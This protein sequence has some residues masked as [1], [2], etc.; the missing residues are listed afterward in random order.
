MR[1]GY[2]ILYQDDHL[3][4]VNKAA[5][6]LSIPDRYQHDKKNLQSL[7]KQKFGEAY[8]VHR[9]DR[10]TSGLMIF[11]LNEEV[12]RELSLAF[13]NRKVQK[14]YNALVLGVPNPPE[15]R[16]DTLITNSEAA[17]NKM[18]V[19]K[20]GKRS[21]TDYRLIEHYGHRYSLLE[22]NIL[23]GRTHQIRVHMQHIGHPLMV[24]P[25]YGKA[26]TFKLSEI[27]KRNYRLAKFEEEKPLLSRHTLHARRLSFIHPVTQQKLSV[28]ADLPK[29][30]KAVINQCRKI[31][32]TVIVEG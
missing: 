20:K 16:I 17:K 6:L 8:L 14:I 25:L 32:G 4:V 27:K 7:I 2:K 21:I 28:E 15:G 3:L 22:I 26:S 18:I 10:D 5:G 19:Y 30:M 24:D 31:L 13:E 29:D 11:A 9:I 23:T 1:R 12:H